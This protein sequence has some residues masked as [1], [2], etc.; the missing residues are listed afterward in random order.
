MADGED[1]LLRS[2]ESPHHIQQADIVPQIL[3]RP[4]AKNEH[5]VIVLDFYLI[6][7][8]ICLEP[9]TLSFDVGV[10]SRLEVVHHKMQ[11]PA[12][13]SR[14]HGLPALLPKPVNRIKRFIRLTAI[15][16]DYKNSGHAFQPHQD[17]RFALL[18]AQYYAPPDVTGKPQIT[19]NHLDLFSYENPSVPH[20]RQCSASRPK[21]AARRRLGSG[22]RLLIAQNGANSTAISGSSGGNGRLRDYNPLEKKRLPIEPPPNA[23]AAA[24][25]IQKILAW[26]EPTE[27]TFKKTNREAKL[28]PSWQETQVLGFIRYVG[29]YAADLNKSYSSNRVDSLAQVLRNLAELDV[30]VEFCGV[31]VENAKRFFDDMARDIREVIE[32]HNKV[33]LHKYKTPYEGL[34]DLIKILTE[35]SVTLQVKNLEGRF[36]Q[37]SQAAK[38]IGRDLR[39]ASMYKI[40]SKYAHPTA[41]LLNGAREEQVLMDRFYDVGARTAYSCVITIQKTITKRYPNFE[42]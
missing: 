29:F 22:D 42:L 10:P 14:N 9:I 38:E 3:G 13:R 24:E 21:S 4:A 30:W 5:C 15:P 19:L 11:P 6:E 36:T 23:V 18:A 26:V 7:C 20:G 40:A 39:Y 1:P 35:S 12:C 28:F 17:F 2:I 34:D 37:V 27:E 41:L 32:T 8:Q 33:H 31:A 16:R 25:A